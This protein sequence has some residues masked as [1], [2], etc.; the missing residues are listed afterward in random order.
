MPLPFISGSAQAAAVM[1]MV[2][3]TV[4][5]VNSRANS[6]SAKSIEPAV[7]V[8]PSLRVTV[9]VLSMRLLLTRTPLAVAMSEMLAMP[10]A[11]SPCNSPASVT[12]SWSRSRHSRT[13][14]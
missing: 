8:R 7:V 6:F 10:A 4:L 2:P 11:A 14:A 5:P 1:A 13:S 3:C 12:P 9:E